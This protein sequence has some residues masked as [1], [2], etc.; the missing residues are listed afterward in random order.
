MGISPN[1]IRNLL[2][3]LGLSD[4]GSFEPYHPRVRDR[5]D[6]AVLRCRR[7]GVLILSRTDH[8][9]L[10]HYADAAGFTYWSTADRA[11]AVLQG[12][13]DDRRRA[14]Q[15]QEAIR[16]RKWLDVGT[17]AGGILDLLLPVAGSVQAVEPQPAA[18]RALQ[19]AG[20]R[21]YGALADVTCRDLDVVTL[22]HV[23][24]HFL[25]P[26]E[27]LRQLRA[28]MKPGAL[29]V[30]EVPHARDFLLEFLQLEAFKDFTLWSE[31]LIL[32][33][34]ASLATFVSAAGY[35]DVAVTGFQRYPLANHLH[36]LAKGAPGGHVK[37]P[38]LRAPD[39]ESAYA[40][41]LEALDMTDTLIATARA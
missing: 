39:L 9:S 19:E 32:H 33:T 8:I 29:L 21:V 12:V 11:A 41:R 34:R 20:Y 13:E 40:A 31:H 10:A 28:R 27:E 18:R 15:W 25:D 23:L 17:G 37:W 6:V 26:V 3:E 38:S 14:A 22:F 35:T 36:W 4:S 7:S 5:D 24:E 30:I 16:G 1:Q 2:C